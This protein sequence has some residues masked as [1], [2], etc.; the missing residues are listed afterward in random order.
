MCSLYTLEIKKKINFYIGKM[1]RCSDQV[2]QILWGPVWEGGQGPRSK[3]PGESQ[4][5]LWETLKPSWSVD[6]WVAFL[7]PNVRIKSL[8]ALRWTNVSILSGI[9]YL[10]QE[11]GIMD[12]VYSLGNTCY[13]IFKT[14]KTKWIDIFSTHKIK[15]LQSKWERERERRGREKKMSPEAK[16]HGRCVFLCHHSSI[17]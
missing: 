2:I 12:G 10:S 15:G 11:E 1:D 16:W 5:S 6:I 7:G 13:K 9:K 14:W 3:K 17:D 4:S 8:C